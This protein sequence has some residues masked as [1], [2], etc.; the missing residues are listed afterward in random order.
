MCGISSVMR[1]GVVR[2]THAGPRNL[3]QLRP[4]IGHSIISDAEAV[5]R[6][7]QVSSAL[8]NKNQP[9]KVSAFKCLQL[10]KSDDFCLFKDIFDRYSQH[11]DL[12]V[13]IC[14]KFWASTSIRCLF[15]ENL[16]KLWSFEQWHVLNSTLE[17]FSQLNKISVYSHTTSTDQENSAQSILLFSAIN[18][19]SLVGALLALKFH[20]QGVKVHSTTL[21]TVYQCLSAYRGTEVPHYNY[22]ILRLLNTFEYELSASQISAVLDMAYS[23]PNDIYLTNL[24]VDKLESHIFNAEYDKQLVESLESVIIGNFN[25]GHTNRGIELWKRY[26]TKFIQLGTS[27]AILDH[28]I[29]TGSVKNIVNSI[30]WDLVDNGVLDAAIVHYGSDKDGQL[31]SVIS[32]VRSPVKRLTLSSLLFAFLNQSR[33]KE[34]EKILLAILKTKSGLTKEDF[35]VIISDLLKNNKLEESI[36]MIDSADTHISELAYFTIF[37]YILDNEDPKQFTQFFKNMDHHLKISS[38][39]TKK[40]VLPVVVKYIYSRHHLR[41][42]R[43]F[44]SNLLKARNDEA[45]PKPSLNKL[46]LDGVSFDTIIVTDENLVSSLFSLLDVSY[47]HED[48]DVMTWGI[49]QLRLCGFLLR[50]ILQHLKSID[51]ERY[52]DMFVNL[53]V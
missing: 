23:R 19:E 15:I 9:F 37:K 13:S 35:N 2:F 48:I 30:N 27:N 45:Y 21:N 10:Y 25:L 33:Y 6:L 28:I 46:W 50:E 36:Q 8:S 12:F 26:T 44:L 39:D 18:G 38:N 41:I 32:K 17:K 47:K 29:R 3:S 51:E 20:N 53:D 43:A 52:R 24:L 7:S 40:M 1:P 11:E 4:G 16:V 49:E 42:A 31:D 34:S 22:A 14:D 5:Y